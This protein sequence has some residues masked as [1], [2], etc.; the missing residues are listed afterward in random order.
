MR[1]N[2]SAK[3][4]ALFDADPE[5]I[6]R[7][8]ATKDETWIYQLQSEPKEQSKLWKYHGILA[9]IKVIA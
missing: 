5:A 8:L 9:L 4:L 6:I 3:N 1:R 7:Y 2:I